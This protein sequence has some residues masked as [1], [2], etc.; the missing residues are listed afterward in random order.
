[1]SNVD[2]IVYY[3]KEN[4]KKIVDYIDYESIDV[5]KFLQQEFNKGDITSNF[6]FQFLYR[7][8]YR[9]D[10]AGLTDE[11]KKEYFRIMEENRNIKNI[12]ISDIVMRLY[13]FKR[14]KGDYSIQF[15]FTTKLINTINV[16][17][18]IYDSE[19]ARVFNFS[20]YNIKDVDKKLK[21]Y[22]KYHSII[23]STYDDIIDNNLLKDTLNLFDRKFIN[24]G[25]SQVKKLDFLV[26]SAGKLLKKK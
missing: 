19:V 16:F 12:N 21:R 4:E 8:F 23:T 13:Y 14:R 20:T 18:P 15:S 7:S 6:L 17:Y 26:W 1:M 9:L 24:N 22:L 5:Y 11:F 2:E 10:N 25:L 3:I